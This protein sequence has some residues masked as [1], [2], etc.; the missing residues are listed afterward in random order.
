[1]NPNHI[2]ILH[3]NETNHI[4]KQTKYNTHNN[5]QYND[6]LQIYFN[7]ATHWTRT[8][9]LTGQN[10]FPA[11]YWPTIHNISITL[12]PTFFNMTILQKSEFELHSHSHHKALTLQNSK[13]SPWYKV[14]YLHN[15][16]ITNITP[17]RFNYQHKMN[18]LT[19]TNLCAT[20]KIINSAD[21][22]CNSKKLIFA[23]FQKLTESLICNQQD[24]I[25]N[26]ISCT[27]LPETAN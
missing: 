15:S 26:W 14:K 11:T 18:K 7:K 13:H 21:R 12:Q 16:I 5:S 20:H 9:T 8:L 17:A 2:S 3:S 24:V 27:F 4:S 22:I 10:N 1:M 25:F 6:T 19:I 23:H